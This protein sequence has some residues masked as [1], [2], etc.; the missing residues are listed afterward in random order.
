M[1]TSVASSSSSTTNNSDSSGEDDMT[2]LDMLLSIVTRSVGLA[3]LLAILNGDLSSLDRT[4][5]DMYDL[6]VTLLNEEDSPAI[7]AAAAQHH[8]AAIT[9]AVLT[10][11][12]LATRAAQLRP[13]ADPATLVRPLVEQS[14]NEFFDEVLRRHD[15]QE[16]GGAAAAALPRYSHFLRAWGTDFLGSVMDGLV[17]EAYTDGIV[18]ASALMERAAMS[19]LSQADGLGAMAPLVGGSIKTSLVALYSSWKQRQQ[20]EEAGTE[21]GGEDEPWLRAVPEQE[22]ATWRQVVARD[23]VTMDAEGG[24]AQARIETK[25]EEVLEEKSDTST[26]H[27][28]PTKPPS[29]VY[30]EGRSDG[31]MR[32]GGP[33]KM[34]T[35]ES[36]SDESSESLKR[37]MDDEGE[38]IARK[39]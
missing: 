3:D 6:V 19:R 39:K 16:E 35:D 14:L 8:A 11:E 13:G 12:V 7:R 26:V 5:H 37:K 34:E 24:V 4:E 29:S 21:A 31:V 33:H 15:V 32:R 1:A 2:L 30:R 38:K 22:R 27:S 9:A 25:Q 28:D 23:R 17:R 10:P 20:A 36:G 18:S